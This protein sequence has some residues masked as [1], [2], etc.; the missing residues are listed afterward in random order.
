MIRYLLALFLLF[1]G[2][3][4]SQSENEVRKSVTEFEQEEDEEYEN[5]EGKIIRKITFRVIE[6]TGP[7]VEEKNGEDT[8]WFSDVV[9][10]IHITTK[11]WVVRNY[12]LFEEG[13]PVE[14]YEIS[15][16]ER[17]L[18]ESN[19]FLDS[20]IRIIPV[21]NSD[22]VDVRVI[23]K[24]RW[25]LI[26]QLSFNA[27]TNSYAGF[28][29]DNFLGIGHMLDT[30]VTHD[31]DQIVGWG[32]KTLY[33]ARNLAGSYIDASAGIE[34]NRRS[35]LKLLDLSRPF[36]SLRTR[37][38]GGLSLQWNSSKLLYVTSGSSSLL[39]FSSFTT[40]IW[41][42]YSFPALFGSSVF[43]KKTNII[44][45]AG[46][47]RIN[48]SSRPYVSVDSNRVFTNNIR[49]L[50]TTGI[51]NRRYYREHYLQRFGPTEDIPIGGMLAFT[52]GPE[53]NEFSRRF[54][55]GVEGVYSRRFSNIGYLSLYTSAGGFNNNGSW[56]QNVFNFDLLYH[57]SLYEKNDW[58]WRFFARNVYII[59]NNRLEQEQLFLDNDT[60]LRG[61]ERFS[62]H[63]ISSGLLKTEFRYFTPF[64][65]L[66]FAIGGS[67]FSD[68]GVI[69]DNGERLYNS[70]LYQSYGAGLRI[71]NESISTAQFDVAIV[72]RPFTPGNSKGSF[73]LLFSSSMIMGS[74]NFNFLKPSTIKY[75]EN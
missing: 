58:R 32:T 66:G 10:T 52:G 18:R 62:L 26:P 73:A 12:L 2:I 46:M 56:E 7:S 35:S 31:N 9:N 71:A 24:D 21:E 23:T 54:Y 69:A 14:S 19:F 75:G 29:D 43:R 20:R 13:D 11:D 70:K 57:S 28:K 8:S 38:A 65:P 64:K 49:Y 53:I 30:R 22:S 33:T 6:V 42:G 5:F 59:G 44:V 34:T 41:G 3:L 50:F 1:Q 45:S 55:S 72:F 36:V 63:G 51:L 17:L 67:V 74:R 48:F 60:G 47:A 61:Y 25:T 15:E 16:S 37:I 40:D 39:P 27:Q 4:F 68:F